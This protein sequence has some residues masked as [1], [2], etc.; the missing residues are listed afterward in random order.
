MFFLRTWNTNYFYTSK[1]KPLLKTIV[2]RIP[3]SDRV[4]DTSNVEFFYKL[5][6]DLGLEFA[7]YTNFSFDLLEEDSD[8]DFL[9]YLRNY[10]QKPY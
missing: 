1:P 6:K 7:D 2:K 9:L 5:N 3:L 8:D 4:I 10:H